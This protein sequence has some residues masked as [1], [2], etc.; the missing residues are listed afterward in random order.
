M[1]Y[2]VPPE[3]RVTDPER[4]AAIEWQVT[5]RPYTYVYTD[6]VAMLRERGV[7]AEDVETMFVDNPR[8]LLTGS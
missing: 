3:R 5:N 1:S 2:W 8:R 6:F 4:R 7:S